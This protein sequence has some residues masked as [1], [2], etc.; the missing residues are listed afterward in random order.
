MGKINMNASPKQRLGI[1]SRTLA[2][3]RQVGMVTGFAL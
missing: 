3:L 2:T 1:A